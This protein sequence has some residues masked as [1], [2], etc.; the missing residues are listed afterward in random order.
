MSLRALHD[1]QHQSKTMPVLTWSDGLVKG[2]PV[3]QASLCEGEVPVVH[4]PFSQT[5]MPWHSPSSK[6]LFQCVVWPAVH[7]P[8]LVATLCEQ[9]MCHES[10]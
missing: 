10:R 3:Q 6:H 5:A 2:W 8:G 1:P 4:A 9:P 7:P